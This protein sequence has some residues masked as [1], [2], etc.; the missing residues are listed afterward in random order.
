[1]TSLDSVNTKNTGPR[2][3]LCEFEYQSHLSVLNSRGSLVS[4]LPQNP[5][6]AGLWGLLGAVKVTMLS[7]VI[8]S[9][10]QSCHQPT[11]M[12]WHHAPSQGSGL[13]LP[14][15]DSRCLLRGV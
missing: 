7:I 15:P 6:L 13:R 9:P 1:M 14:P 3:L 11:T 4:H 2:E 10:R 12:L 8:Y 5:P